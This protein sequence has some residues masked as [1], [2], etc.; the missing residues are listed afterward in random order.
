MMGVKAW[1]TVNGNHIPIMDGE[2]K[3]QAV[4]KFFNSRKKINKQDYELYSNMAEHAK[5]AIPRWKS[6]GDT[7]MVEYEKQNAKKY[8]NKVKE[9]EPQVERQNK[10][11]TIK[12]LRY[13]T[14]SYKLKSKEYEKDSSDRKVD[15]INKLKDEALKL[16]Y[17]DDGKSKIKKQ[18]VKDQVQNALDKM[19]DG[20]TLYHIYRR[21]S[22]GYT[23]FG[24]Y[25]DDSS[26]AI[27]YAKINGQWR[28]K[29]YNDGSKLVNKVSKKDYKNWDGAQK[30]SNE[31][32]YIGLIYNDTIL[33]GKQAKSVLI[34]SRAGDKSERRWYGSNK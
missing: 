23:T 13:K 33:S 22:S 7:H 11:N 19:P 8:E 30:M 24:G 29:T 17:K 15:R 32:M 27:C 18:K 6:K 3:I 28:K 12:G 16:R 26:E 4:G 10:H 5:Q 25:S 2:S 21:N 34:R 9:L 14:F 1:I 31:D 20:T